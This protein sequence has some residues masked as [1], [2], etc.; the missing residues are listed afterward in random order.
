MSCGV[1]L[2]GT[3]LPAAGSICRFAKR[4]GLS[5]RRRAVANAL[6]G[7]FVG[8]SG[9]TAGPTT[10]PLLVTGRAGGEGCTVSDGRVA[11]NE[12]CPD[13]SPGVKLGKPGSVIR[14]LV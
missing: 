2:T 3:V 9:D 12:N 6:V 8:D 1:V 4:S 10:T 14:V 5:A 11:V 7:K 13:S